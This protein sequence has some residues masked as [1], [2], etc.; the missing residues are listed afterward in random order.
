M[1]SASIEVREWVIRPVLSLVTIERTWTRVTSGASGARVYRSPDGR[2]H[3]KLVSPERVLDLAGERDRV[4]WLDPTGIPGPA[5]LDWQT[6]NTGACLVT[7]TVEGVT[8]DQVSPGQLRQAWPSIVSATRALHALPPETCPFTRSLTEMWALAEDVVA[9]DAVIT[10][11]LPVEQPLLARDHSRPT[12]AD[13]RTG[14]RPPAVLPAP[15]PT[16]LGVGL[17]ALLDPLGGGGL[18]QRARP[19]PL[20]RHGGGPAPRRDLEQLR[21]STVSVLSATVLVSASA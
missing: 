1:R 17:P 4:E 6:T 19:R 15:G 20:R 21:H 7:S 11:F 3:A 5:V 14:P 13:D 10:A 2:R 8:A 16:H 18:G 9:R 12:L